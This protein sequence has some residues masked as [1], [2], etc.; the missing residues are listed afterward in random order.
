MLERRLLVNLPQRLPEV[1]KGL[2]IAKRSTRNGDDLTGGS[3]AF[4]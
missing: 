3:K 2:D 1:S 4:D